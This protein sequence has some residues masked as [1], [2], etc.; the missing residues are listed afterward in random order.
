[1]WGLLLIE[2]DWTMRSNH[3]PVVLPVIMCQIIVTWVVTLRLL[4]RSMSGFTLTGSSSRS[5]MPCYRTPSSVMSALSSWTVRGRWKR[6]CVGA[7]LIWSSER[8]SIL[9]I[10][11][12]VIVTLYVL[13]YAKFAIVEVRV[14][15]CTHLDTAT[16]L[17]Y[18]TSSGNFVRFS[19]AQVLFLLCPSQFLIFI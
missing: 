12:V 15:H 18:T 10:S 16:A 3:L 2:K 19:F 1:M 5:I 6:R 11:S 7:L 14:E 4:Q 17:Q 8:I 13:S 9:Y